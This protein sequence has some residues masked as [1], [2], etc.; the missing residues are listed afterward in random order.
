MGRFVGHQTA[1]G[2]ETEQRKLRQA[3]DRIQEPGAPAEAWFVHGVSG[4]GKSFLVE[5]VINEKRQESMLLVGYG[6]Y[7]QCTNASVPYEAISLA[8]TDVCRTLGKSAQKADVSTRIRNYLNE[9]EIHLLVRMVP[10]VGIFLARQDDE[11]VADEEAPLVDAVI[12]TKGPTVLDE[13]TAIRFM[14]IFRRLLLA[15]SSVQAPLILFLDDLQWAD[16]ASRLLLESI[17]TDTRLRNLLLIGTVRDGERTHFSIDMETPLAVH[18]IVCQTLSESDVTKI[19]GCAIDRQ[20]SDL[21]VLSLGSLVY[22]RCEGNPFFVLQLLEKLERDRLLW[23]SDETQTYEWDATAIQAQ[24]DTT[25]NVVDMLV[26][27]ISKVSRSSRALLLVFSLIGH[28]VDEHVIQTALRSQA[29]VESL[30]P[31]IDQQGDGIV[32]DEPIDIIAAIRETK[33][34]GL[35]ERDETAK[36]FKFVHDRVQQAVLQMIEGT[37]FENNIMSKMG[38]FLLDISRSSKGKDWMMFMATNML[39]KD[40]G[41]M[42]MGET[43]ML[44]L[45]CAQK[46]ISQSAFESAAGFADSGCRVLNENGWRAYHE[47]KVELET[48][49]VEANFAGGKLSECKR[50]IKAL[51]KHSENVKD[52]FRCFN[53]SVRMKMLEEFWS[54][55]ISEC[56]R[57]MKQLNVNL[58]RRPSSLY[59]IRKF[60]KVKR[61]LKGRT[62]TQLLDDLPPCRD[63]RVLQLHSLVSDAIV[64][65]YWNTEIN[66]LCC[67]CILSLDLTLKHGMCSWTPFAMTSYASFLT[68]AGTAED[69][70]AFGECAVNLAKQTSYSLPG[71]LSTFHLLSNHLRNPLRS[72][73]AGFKAARDTASQRGDTIIEAVSS[74][75]FGTLSVFCGYS[76]HDL[77]R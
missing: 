76:L 33:E 14:N 57:G 8:I 5:Q 68:V 69:A 75:T 3:F 23:Y 43:A 41:Q 20:P 16:A 6:K 52:T 72:S 51:K 24:M 30:R 9:K 67:L 48:V 35:V 59:M 66:L 34:N 36:R 17:M 71:T 27:K 70:F 25:S 64:A 74:K 77:K 62:P 73:V 61:K 55:C 49:A 10:A 29:L 15:V 26:T 18:V 63:Q 60:L 53:V 37:P 7:D 21:D 39:T 28:S 38:R 45:E 22:R 46:A 54:P 56:L 40:R 31:I 42:G 2:R 58:P 4:C 50:R 12:P 44:C 47:L 65:T 13:T 32:R 19:V 11:N 1:V